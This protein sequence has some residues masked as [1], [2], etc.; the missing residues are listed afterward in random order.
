MDLHKEV[1][2]EAQVV[3][4]Q[5]LVEGFMDG[6]ASGSSGEASNDRGAKRWRIMTTQKGD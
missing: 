4:P 2:R 5:G 3:M 6:G 1:V